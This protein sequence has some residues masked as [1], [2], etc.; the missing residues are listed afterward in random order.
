MS[1]R[2]GRTFLFALPGKREGQVG[3]CGWSLR[4]AVT[5]SE[6]ATSDVGTFA[7]VQVLGNLF[8]GE[9]RSLTEQELSCLAILLEKRNG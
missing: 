7:G 2:P 6:K 8:E 4:A 1:V 3:L 9:Q 5:S